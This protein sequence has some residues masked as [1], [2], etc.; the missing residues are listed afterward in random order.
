VQ[1][2]LGTNQAVQR[3]SREDPSVANDLSIRLEL[4]ADCFAGVWGASVYARGI[5]QPGDIE[6]ALGAAA[7]VGD[8]RIQKRTQG[9]IDPETF[10]HG[11][12]AQRVRWFRAGFETGDP[13][14]C[15]TFSGEV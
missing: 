4:Q 14:A 8:D 15:D 3:A 5:L 2:L 12:S 7:A 1:T 11:T 10:M 9:R 13:A 6:E